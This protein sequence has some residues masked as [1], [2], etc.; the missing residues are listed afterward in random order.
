MFQLQMQANA[1][2]DMEVADPF[3]IFTGH[4]D[5]LYIFTMEDREK[6]I[7]T[8]QY[9]IVGNRKYILIHATDFY[10]GITFNAKDVG[11]LMADSFIWSE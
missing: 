6:N 11:M 5:P 1:R 3:W 8:I 2:S 10:N 7:T 4:D 9:Y